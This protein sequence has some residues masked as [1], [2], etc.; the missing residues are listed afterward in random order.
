MADESETM[1]GRVW[2]GRRTEGRVGV[3]E[4]MGMAKEGMEGGSDMR[5]G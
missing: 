4:G 1:G 2:R 5:G 3:R